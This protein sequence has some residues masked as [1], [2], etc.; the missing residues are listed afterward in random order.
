LTVLSKKFK[1]WK[2]P[3]PK[4]PGNP[5]HKEKTT[6]RIRRIEAREDFQL[7]RLE[8]IFNKIIKGY[9]PNLKKEMTI[10]EKEAYRTTNK[11]D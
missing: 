4:H 10:N 8:N 3:N 9:F 6:L 1:T 7:K 11:L 5:R 2:T